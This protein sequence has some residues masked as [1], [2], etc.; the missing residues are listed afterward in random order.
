MSAHSHP[1]RS[2]CFAHLEQTSDNTVGTGVGHLVY[3]CG[4]PP[5]PFMRKGSA[6]APAA[7]VSA[8]GGNIPPL[9]WFAAH[10]M[11]CQAP[12][13]AAVGC[14]AV[15]DENHPASPQPQSQ[16]AG[17]CMVDLGVKSLIPAGVQ[18]L[19]LCRSLAA[20]PGPLCPCTP[21]A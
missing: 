11:G 12:P 3:H 18:T 19:P 2:P 7:S 13:R 6:W 1:R 21:P 17:C 5:T 9:S 20:C 14:Q 8:L 4:V 15:P 16:P 10:R